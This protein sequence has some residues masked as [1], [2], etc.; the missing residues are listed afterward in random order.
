M[1]PF[2]KWA[3]NKY[4]IITRIQ[5]LLPCGKRL[6]EPFVGSGAVFLNTDYPSYEL[7]DCNGDLIALYQHVQREGD[8]FID[9]CQTFFTE[10]NNT[11]EAYYAFR[12]KFNTTGD[13]RLK[14][15][16]FVYFNKHGYNGLCRYNASGGFNVPFGHVVIGEDRNPLTPLQR[17][18]EATG[19]GFHVLKAAR[20]GQKVA[21]LRVK[22]PLSLFRRHSPSHKYSGEGAGQTRRLYHRLG[23]TL[24]LGRRADPTAAG[25]GQ[26]DPEECRHPGPTFLFHCGRNTPGGRPLCAIGSSSMDDGQRPRPCPQRIG[27]R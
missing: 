7:S 22:K 1:K 8:A 9:Y 16:L 26:F 23:L 3:G 4:Q 19:G 24:R 14:S 11:P 10:E 12:A 20:V 6:I 15:A 17:H 13:V 5:A 25:R 27:L 21:E 18:N 2:L